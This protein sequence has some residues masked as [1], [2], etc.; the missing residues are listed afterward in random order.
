MKKIWIPMMIVLML[1][2]LSFISGPMKDLKVYISVDM[3]GIAGVVAVSECSSKGSDYDYFRRIMTL[4]TNAAVEGAIA[5]GATEIVVRDGHGAK[6]NIVPDL[7]HRKARLLRGIT[8]EPENM[9]LGIDS[10]FDA[11]LFIGYHAKAGT[12]EGVL[13]HTSS[14]NVIDLSIN[15]VSLPEAGYNALVA[16]LHDVPVAFIAGDNWICQQAKKLF[17]DVET[18]ET[19]QGF[20][21]AELGLH[22]EAVR[23]KI[24]EKVLG[25][26]QNPERFK[27][28]K[29][30]P[31]YT[32]VLKVKK[33]K[34]LYPGAEETGQ[35]EFRFTSPDLLE[36][37]DAFNKMK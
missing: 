29:M 13:A 36:V 27:P 12:K 7:L 30:Q 22:P 20:G 8:D 10:T 9:M 5:A 3:E 31:P 33:A 28:Y 14:G 24:R 17:G 37:L 15:N 35:N 11:V 26:L 16:G 21:T 19:K 4:E 25:A 32:M 34:P 18:L 2:S 6:T 1:G 23:E